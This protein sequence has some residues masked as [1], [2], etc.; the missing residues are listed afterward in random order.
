MDTETGKD[1]DINCAP[2]IDDPE[3]NDAV[4]MVILLQVVILILILRLIE[5]VRMMLVL[6]TLLQI[7]TDIDTDSNAD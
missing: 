4:P 3:A 5:I 6:L 2:D 1:I 7:Y